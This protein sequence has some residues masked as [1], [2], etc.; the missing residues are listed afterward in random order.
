[1]LNK[2]IAPF[3][4]I[5]LVLAMSSCSGETPAD[6]DAQ[7]TPTTS[8]VTPSEVEAPVES[9]SLSPDEE[10]ILQLNEAIPE[11]EKGNE[12]DYIRLADTFCGFLDEG[13]TPQ[14][15]INSWAASGGDAQRAS[16]MLKIAT[17]IYCPQ[18]TKVVE[19]NVS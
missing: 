3:V 11:T 8:A 2:L 15:I 5:L 9:P 17:P 1:M 10:F 4:G 13:Y 7:S 16:T 18:H 6:A 12:A 19:I 14:G